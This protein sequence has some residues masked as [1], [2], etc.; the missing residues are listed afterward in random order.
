MA[1]ICKIPLFGVT[2]WK[3]QI[4]EFQNFPYLTH[5]SKSDLS[6]IWSTHYKSFFFEFE[7]VSHPI[8][9]LSTKQF[10]LIHRPSCLKIRP[11]I[12]KFFWTKPFHWQISIRF[13]WFNHTQP[14]LIVCLKIWTRKLYFCFLIGWILMKFGQKRRRKFWLS[15]KE[16]WT[17]VV[18]IV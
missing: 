4:R 7:K 8:K 1:R 5:F 18:R 13:K 10:V 15:I 6:L 14:F 3:W 9:V 17:Y 11:K 16:G 2:S 12:G